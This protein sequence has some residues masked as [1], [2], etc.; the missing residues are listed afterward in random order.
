MLE[1]MK[2]ACAIGTCLWL[3]LCL[4]VQAQDEWP[5]RYHREEMKYRFGLQ[6]EHWRALSGDYDSFN[7]GSFLWEERFD[8]FSGGMTLGGGHVELTPGS[9]ADSQTGNPYVLQT[10]VFA[11]YHFAPQRVPLRPYVAANVN[12]IN[13][14]WSYRTP[15]ISGNETIRSDYAQGI[16]AAAAFGL[17]I[18][19]AK[20]LHL[21][22]E[23]GF[24]AVGM[25]D[26]TSENLH[27]DLFKSFTYAN[28]KVGLT[29]SF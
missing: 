13:I 24:G 28:F 3:F 10:G 21:F 11:R 5:E 27:N 29:F 18:E 26:R 9:F 16:G 17:S 19:A 14:G 25:L 4:P 6:F 1:R 20:N 22:G 12:L 23:A 7:I 15:L 8:N 2:R